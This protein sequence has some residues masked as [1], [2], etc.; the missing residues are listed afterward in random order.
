[1]RIPKAPAWPPFAFAAM[2]S[3]SVLADEVIPFVENPASNSVEWRE[4]VEAVDGTFETVDLDMHPTGPLILDFFMDSLGVSFTEEGL[5]D[6]AS[7]PGPGEAGVD[8]IGGTKIGEGIHDGSNYIF[9]PQGTSELVIT[10]DRPVLGAG[11]YIIDY[12]NPG[13]GI[14][15]L[16]LE[17]FDG[18]DGSGDSLGWFLSARKVNLQKNKLYFMGV[19]DPAASIRSV[20]FT[21]IDGNLGDRTGIGDIVFARLPDHSVDDPE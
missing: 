12:F 17:A 6:V 19:V 21:D 8:T 4:A 20:V 2:L 3:T 13:S 14:N 18:V 11:L 9:D 7:G 10:F 1:M 16:R 15:R 5:G